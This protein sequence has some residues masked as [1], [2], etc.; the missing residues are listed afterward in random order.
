MSGKSHQGR[1]KQTA[2]SKR[3]KGGRD[4]FAAVAQQQAVVPPQEAVAHT[5]V[6]DS[7][8]SVPTPRATLASV[9]HPYIGSELRRIGILAGIILVILAVLAQVLP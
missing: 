5:K 8:A 6:P 3:R 4:H 2:R 7:V 9:Q 1:R